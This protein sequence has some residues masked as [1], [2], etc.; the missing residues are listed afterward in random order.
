LHQTPRNETVNLVTDKIVTFSAGRLSMG[1]V[2]EIGGSLA[3]FRV[4]GV[5]LMRPLSDTDL[6]AEN[7]LGVAMFPMTPYANRIDGNSF[8][9][10]GQDWHVEANNPPERFNVHGTGWHRPWQAR[11]GE[12]S[13]ELSLDIVAPDEPYSYH[14]VQNFVLTPEG[15]SVDMQLTNRGHVPMPFGF[16]LHPWFERTPETT[17][18]FAATHFFME[19]P[20]GIVTERLALPRE[21]DFAGGRVLPDTWRN[22]DYGG[23]GGRVD[24]RF[25]ERKLG[26]RI[27]ADPIFGHLMLYADPQKPY[28]CVEPQSNAPCAFN[29]MAGPYGEAFGARVLAPG[30]SMAGSIRFLPLT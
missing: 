4:D 17:L 25:P 5:D 28:F 16:G 15:L 30:E 11:Q 12:S 10:G 24:I 2:P 18:D 13:I 3:Y 22:N 26:L 1:V 9:F 29:R 23:W 27:E 20:E 14:A 19:G 7:V 21:L 8:R 6:A